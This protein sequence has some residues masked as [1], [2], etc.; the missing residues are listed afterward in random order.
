MAAPSP[1]SR[2]ALLALV[3]QAV[4][5]AA[6]AG[7]AAPGPEPRRPNVLVLLSDDQRTDAVSALG[8]P[9][10]ETPNLDTLVRRG[11]S[12]REAHVMGSHHGAVCRPS[13]AMLLSGRQLFDVYDDLDGVVT[14]PERLRGAGYATFGTGKWHQSRESFARSFAEGRAVFFGGMSD[15]TRVPVQDLRPDG[16]FGE[17]REEGFSSVVFAD[18]AVAFLDARAAA[19]DGRPFFA[20]VAFTAPHDP[21]TPPDGYRELYPPE[22]VPLPGNFRPVHPFHNG[23]MTGRDEQLAAWPRDPDVIRAQIAEYWGLVTHMDTQVGRI[24][25]ALRRNGMADDTLIV[26]ASDN[27]LALGSHGLLGK[28]SLYEHSTR[29]PLVVAGPGVPHGESAALVYLY[30]LF[31]TIARRAGLDPLPGIAGADLAP[32]WEGRRAGVRDTLFTAY[33]DLQRAVRDGR[34][35]LIRYPRL[36]HTQLFDLRRDP[37]E[38]R[39]RAAEPEQA[40]RVERMM[41]LL[42]EWQERTGD[43]HPLTAETRDPMEFD[44]TQV[45]RTPDRHQPESVVRKYFRR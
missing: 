22:A 44:Y 15:H 14:L 30:D 39:N 31:P 21:R 23:W 18:A 43:P 19:G 9:Y 45:E 5:A 2:L 27:G 4:A 29:V 41:A 16:T 8:N 24:L 3:A 1:C 13:R 11:F 40:A 34:W 32:V 28:Q 20:W 10:V 25:D 37:L 6:S 12:F 42:G 36:H 7:T 38:L 33:E 35:K 17:A 26:F